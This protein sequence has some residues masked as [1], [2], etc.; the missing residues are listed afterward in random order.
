MKK[1]VYLVVLVWLGINALSFSY[2]LQSAKKEQENIALLSARSFFNQI[3]V[4]RSWNAGHGGV[5][6][7]VTPE[8]QPNKYLV[9][10]RREIVVDDNLILTK[11]NPAFMT[12]QIAEIAAEKD[13]IQFHITSLNPIR[14]DNRP[15][16]WEAAV[17]KSFEEGGHEF[18]ELRNFEGKKLYMYMGPLITEKS[19]LKCHASHGYQEGDIRGGISVT[20]P[21]VKNVSIKS[22]LLAHLIIALAGCIGIFLS[23][24]ALAAAYEKIKVQA[25]FDALTEIP[26]RRS[27]TEELLR[28]FHRSRRDKYPLSLIMCD[29]DNFKA[30]ND[31]CGHNKG[32]ECLRMIAQIMEKTINRP[33]DFC[34][35]YGGEEFVVILPNTPLAGAEKLAESLRLAVENMQV[36]HS[37]SGPYKV[38]TLSLGVAT[39]DADMPKSHEEFIHRADLALYSAKDSGKN[40]YRVY[41]GNTPI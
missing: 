37:A 34:A 26:N 18:G 11:I 10:A 22:L 27:F 4:T 41:G 15:T 38:V 30:Y 35:R 16:D 28:E 14:P 8:T 3:L 21:F 19:C 25:A 23:G 6:V 12:R 1:I 20:L 5:Y 9:D 7:P 33:G 31:T 24:T 36:E 40:C 32:D 13:G 2:N 39:I 17:L 29:V